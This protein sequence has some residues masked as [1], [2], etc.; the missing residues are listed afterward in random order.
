MLKKVNVNL[1]PS[2]EL[3]VLAPLFAGVPT[4]FS[5]G[6]TDVIA[7]V[8]A[9]SMGYEVD[10]DPASAFD[11]GECIM[12]AFTPDGNLDITTFSYNDLTR[13]VVDDAGADDEDVIIPKAHPIADATDLPSL[14]LYEYGRLL[15]M[16]SD[17]D[18]NERDDGTDMSFLA[19]V[20]TKYEEYRESGA[21]TSDFLKLARSMS[22]LVND[23]EAKCA[24]SFRAKVVAL[25]AILAASF[26]QD[27]S[28]DYTAD[29]VVTMVNKM[30]TVYGFA[31][32]S[33]S[34]T[35]FRPADISG[36]VPSILKDT[37]P[38]TWNLSLDYLLSHP[39]PD[40]SKWVRLLKKYFMQADRAQ[41]VSV[42]K[43]LSASSDIKLLKLSKVFRNAVVSDEI[44][45]HPYLLADILGDP[46]YPKDM[47]AIVKLM[48]NQWNLLGVLMTPATG[49]LRWFVCYM[50]DVDG[51]IIKRMRGK[52]VKDEGLDLKSNGVPI[53]GT[54]AKAEDFDDEMLFDFYKGN[55]TLL[56][57]QDKSVALFT[58]LLDEIIWSDGRYV[59][60]VPFDEYR[61]LG[62]VV[63]KDF[64]SAP[65]VK[66]FANPKLE[67]IAGYLDAIMAISVSFGK[68][69]A[70]LFGKE[71]SELFQMVRPQVQPRRS[72][73]Q[74]NPGELNALK[75]RRKLE[76]ITDEAPSLEQHQAPVVGDIE[77][78][79]D[80]S[81]N[82]DSGFDAWEELQ[83]L[84]K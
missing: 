19:K 73:S 55:T 63:L 46:N 21:Y 36:K 17:T 29:D 72:V 56:A 61:K 31:T 82:P 24:S 20:F 32:V 57:F 44:K 39:N 13:G 70:E 34:A 22:D 18:E 26:L 79:D 69:P 37:F 43:E 7:K 71:L 48:A 50:S 15:T 42:V 64:T 38:T 45:K 47:E 14:T 33:R 41:K 76:P 59:E 3:T 6:N 75:E 23:I 49:N 1:S 8:V 53:I 66:L 28:H 12:Y 81:D 27:L 52:I 54:N 78:T 51:F 40:S 67:S 80:V 62:L 25:D 74:M 30:K 11:S 16:L 68:D 5:R 65:A 9:E 10:D 83:E 4:V 84:D 2:D 58:P 60:R 35:L 77:L